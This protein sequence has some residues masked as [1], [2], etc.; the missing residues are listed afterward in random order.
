MARSYKQG[1]TTPKGLI[2]T[3][4][5]PVDQRTVVESE[6]DLLSPS[7]NAYPGLMVTVLN[8]EGEGK[9]AYRTYKLESTNASIPTNWVLLGTG[10]EGGGGGGT[11]E[12]IGKFISI[13]FTKVQTGAPAQPVGGTYDNPIPNT[14]GGT[15]WS[16]GPPVGPDTLWMSTASFE[17]TAGWEPGWSAPI[18]VGDTDNI[19]FEF[20]GADAVINPSTDKP[21]PPDGIRSYWHNDNIPASDYWMAIGTKSAG[22]TLWQIF[23]I[24][25]EGG[26]VV[27]QGPTGLSYKNVTY[28]TRDSRITE[29]NKVYGGYFDD[30]EPTN[31]TTEGG[32]PV[33]GVQWTDGI[34]I[35]SGKLWQVKYTFNSTQTIQDVNRLWT[36]PGGLT[37][38]G[39]VDYKF[40]DQFAKP[41][42]PDIAVGGIWEDTS[43]SN[44]VWVAQQTILNGIPQNWN[45]WQ[46]KGNT[47]L[48]GSGVNIVGYD[49]ITNILDHDLVGLNLYDIYVASNEE[50]GA[51]VPGSA[52]DAY[53]YVGAGNGT[54]GT[55]WDNIGTVVGS[56]GAAYLQSFAFTRSS[57]GVP[58]SPTGGTFASP[59]PTTI[60]WFDGYPDPVPDTKVYMSSRFFSDDALINNDL[61]DWKIPTL[62]MDSESTDFQYALK[63]T[64]DATPLPPDQSP[65]TWVDGTATGDFYWMAIGKLDTNGDV[66]LPWTVRRIK[67]EKGDTGVPGVPS[68][69]SSAYLRTDT[70]ISGVSVTGG[71]YTSPVPTTTADGK[72]WTDGIPEGAAGLWYVKSRFEQG[73]TGTH[74]WPAP[75]KILDSTTI[76]FQ[77][78]TSLAK[79]TA[80]PTSKEGDGLW[81]DTVDEAEAG[82]QIT[83]W[84]AIASLTGETWPSIWNIVQVTGEKGPVGDDGRTFVPSSVF[85]RCDDFAIANELFIGQWIDPAQQFA[86]TGEYPTIML[87]SKRYTFSDGIPERTNDGSVNDSN[88]IWILNGVF[89]SVDHGSALNLLE[90]GSP[91]LLVDNA[92]TDYEYSVGVGPTHT[93][94]LD[95]DAN[96]SIWFSD[97]DAIGLGDGA[98]WIA[99]K[100]WSEGRGAPWKVYKIRGEDGAD[101]EGSGPALPRTYTRYYNNFNA[102]TNIAD[103][104]NLIPY[105]EQVDL[106]GNPEFIGDSNS[107]WTTAKEGPTIVIAG[108]PGETTLGS[109][110]TMVHESHP[111]YTG[112]PT[113][114]DGWEL[115]VFLRPPERP[116]VDWGDMTYGQNQFPT[117][118]NDD[119]YEKMIRI[120]YGDIITIRKDNLGEATKWNEGDR[121]KY[122]GD[123]NYNEQGHSAP[124]GVRRADDAYK[125]V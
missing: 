38:T 60:G 107:A 70:D 96:P 18:P 111:E 80:Y 81:F 5:E 105:Y 15:V 117:T 79:P 10:V 33:A 1:M 73:E 13:V 47:G 101:A 68:F 17:S 9:P 92:S 51:T 120:R 69:F 40:S 41:V 113:D 29:L 123:D 104:F 67:G 125:L 20:A 75:L 6:A 121:L 27:P 66:V 97:P 102:M 110:Y 34:P 103:L 116:A 118:G 100:N 56:N 3:A 87:N 78:S 37:D 14:V 93:K 52:N 23:K 25:G 98:Y 21:Y 55:A 89:N 30:P 88:Y 85:V 94:P 12:G 109:L 11:V 65:L 57:T 112:D 86:V 22:V 19:D 72:V 36:S 59:L 44:T 106:L 61:E 82:G 99:Q 53:L 39:T 124:W 84:M 95:P 74:T 48:P 90:W 58:A 8:A 24:V 64:L 42:N 62:A 71:D 45:I 114:Q 63:Q 7:L 31:T 91:T 50:L 49:T 77:F 43:T 35:G 2:M 83:K 46:A 119:N 108:A 4:P 32:T 28:F 122:V 54:A 16:D 115:P 26:G 76:E